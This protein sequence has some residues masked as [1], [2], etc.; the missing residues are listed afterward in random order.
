MTEAAKFDIKIVHQL[1]EKALDSAFLSPIFKPKNRAYGG[2]ATLMNTAL[3]YELAETRALY[4]D[5]I[6]ESGEF[7]FGMFANYWLKK[8]NKYE[9]PAPDD[10][11]PDSEVRW[12]SDVFR[13][14][15]T[16]RAN[17]RNWVAPLLEGTDDTPVWFVVG[18]HAGTTTAIRL[19]GEQNG[20]ACWIVVI[21]CYDPSYP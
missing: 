19:S 9:N 17:L 13:M 11:I 20:R 18:G 12:T 1:A 2:M 14:D 7:A 16:T 21:A 3:N 8:K 15:D 5:F 10:G 6:R 4:T